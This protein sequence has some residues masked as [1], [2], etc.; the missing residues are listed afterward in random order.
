MI[1]FTGRILTKKEGYI[2]S[3]GTLVYYRSELQEKVSVYHK[4]SENIIWIRIDCHG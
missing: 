1:L 4:S 3:G 2:S